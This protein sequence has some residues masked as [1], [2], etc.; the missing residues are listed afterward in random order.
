MV[1]AS[2]DMLAARLVLQRCLSLSPNLSLSLLFFLSACRLVIC[3]HFNSI[4]DSVT[5]C[6]L[7]NYNYSLPL[8]D[9]QYTLHFSSF[10][11]S[12]SSSFITHMHACHMPRSVQ[13]F[14][15]FLLTNFPVRLPL[16]LSIFLPP[17]LCL[18]L[19]GI[20][21]IHISNKQASADLSFT[22]SNCRWA[23][24]NL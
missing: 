6:V 10:A 23:N 7:Y 16:P 14:D 19:S 20:L 17:F 3:T 9:H 11:L 5:S 18:S 15:V 12:S 4:F 8:F 22:Y 24:A 21:T 13:I 2:L 1:R